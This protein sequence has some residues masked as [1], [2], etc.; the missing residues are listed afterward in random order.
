MFTN[1]HRMIE[2]RF[3]GP[4]RAMKASHFEQLELRG[5]EV[6]FL[7][8]SITE[9]GQWHEW[10]PHLAVANRG[11]GGDTTTGVLKRL[12][13][14]T[15]GPPSA[16]L[17]LIGTNDLSL[18]YPTE[19]IAANVDSIVTAVQADAPDAQ[20]VL[21]SVMPRKAKRRERIQ[22]LND[23]Y[24]RIAHARGIRYLDLWPA[25]ADE[26]GALNRAFTADDLHLNGAGYRAWIDLLRPV[27]EG[28]DEHR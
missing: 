16:V 17:L 1:W 6:V 22:E 7:G 11:I 15:A 21:Q 3:L 14:A 2:R 10:F 12:H 4:S 13:T 27:V 24:R 26:N 23:R 5:G 9:G 28:A 25:L 19:E 18:Q 8:D 20:I